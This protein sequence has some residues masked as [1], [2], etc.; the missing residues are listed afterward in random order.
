MQPCFIAKTWY[1]PS[2]LRQV[3]QSGYSQL[4]AAFADVVVLARELSLKQVAEIARG[5]EKQQIKGTFR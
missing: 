1:A 5:I 2:H 4:F 3:S